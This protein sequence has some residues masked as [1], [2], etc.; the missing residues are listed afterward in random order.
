MLWDTGMPEI[1]QTQFDDLR[2]RMWEMGE[3]TGS[4]KYQSP[5]SFL[6]RLTH[7]QLAFQRPPGLGFLREAALIGALPPAHSLRRMFET[8]TGMTPEQFIDYTYAIYPAILVDGR[9]TLSVDWFRPLRQRY[10][11]TV[12]Q[13]YISLVSNTFP[14]SQ[15]FA[16][17][18]K[19]TPVRFASELYES[20]PF[21]RF[22]FLR[23]GSTLHCWHGMVFYR[24]MENLVHSIMS[25]AGPDYIEPYSKIFERHVVNQILELPG[26]HYTE[27]QMRKFLGQESLV[28][29]A[30]VSYPAASVYIEVKTGIFKE[31]VMTVGDADIFSHKTKSLA[32]AIH[33]GWAAAIGM[34]RVSGISDQ[35]RS[36]PRTFLLVVTNWEMAVGNGA[37]LRDMYP[38][39][40]LDYPD[41]DV[42]AVLP[43]DNVF[44]LCVDDF[45][46]LIEAV[47]RDGL[48]LPDFLATCTARNSSPETSRFF[49]ISIL[50]RVALD[51]GDLDWYRMPLQSLRLV[52]PRCYL[53]RRAI[54]PMEISDLQRILGWTRWAVRAIPPACDFPN[55]S[56]SSPAQ[57]SP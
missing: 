9:R 49:S 34:R 54:E 3:C 33:Q 30:L 31:S 32:T 21:S 10:G 12:F 14:E 53:D 55:S 47:V 23:E 22:P 38:D 6:R 28:P 27:D 45:D 39:G 16:K 4:Q 57:R 51:W 19:T 42:E 17:S 26:T 36:A 52:C 2:Q 48:V 44:F 37:N 50:A 56:S 13:R 11:E 7:Q 43:L 18:L 35:V 20:T 25:E 15:E 8:R 41:G 1:S 5:Q 40:K 29:D 24:G 46:R